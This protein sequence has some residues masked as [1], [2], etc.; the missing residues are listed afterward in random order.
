MVFE[1]RAL[2]RHIFSHCLH[3]LIVLFCQVTEEI[4]PGT[5]SSG[6]QVGRVKGE[7]CACNNVVTR[8]NVD[9]CCV[10]HWYTKGSIKHSIT[11]HVNNLGMC[12]KYLK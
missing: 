1:T 7:A 2:N 3:G 12:I 11:H 6:G 4:L 5:S 9:I 10:L 8:G